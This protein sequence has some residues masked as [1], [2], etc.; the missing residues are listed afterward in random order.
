MLSRSSSVRPAL[1]VLAALGAGASAYADA[2][3][4]QDRHFRSPFILFGRSAPAAVPAPAPMA[5][6]PA[7]DDAQFPPDGKPGECWVRVLVPAPVETV[8]E[9]VLTKQESFELVEIPA[10][11]ETVEERVLIR[12]ASVRQEVVPATYKE[13][14]HRVLVAPGYTR[15]VP[16]PAVYETVTE[17]VM[18]K[19]ARSYWKKGTGPYQRIDG[20]T[21]EIMCYVT[22]PAEYE[23]VTRNV[24][25]TPATTRDE[26]V[27]AVYETVK[28]TIIDQPAV[29]KTIEVPAE[30]KTVPVQKVKTPAR[31]ERRVI[32]AEYGTVTR[33]IARGQSRMEWRRIL[34]STNVTPAVIADLQTAL[35]AAGYKVGPADGIYG[36]ATM[37]AVEAFQAT[38]GLPQGGLTYETLEAL[39]VSLAR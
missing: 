19:P 27:A 1:L 23:T 9:K 8:T 28:R 37:Q 22:E 38:K 10:E 5:A 15:K 7:Q 34:C 25:K 29:V 16:V 21:G 17:K 18:T 35:N 39:G 36:A 11:M 12:A 33:Q 32:P 26:S 30:Y 24:I 3:N 14:E 31:L 20:E 6:A 4:N 2:S 13:V